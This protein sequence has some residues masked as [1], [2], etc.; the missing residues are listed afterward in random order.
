MQIKLPEVKEPHVS[1][2]LKFISSRPYRGELRY[3]KKEKG[4]HI[5][6]I[7]PLAMGGDETQKE[8]LVKL[9]PREHY[10]AHLILWK[11][12]GGK[13]AYAFR[14]MQG[15]GKITSRQ[16]ENLRFE[17]STLS[18]S[19]LLGIPLTAEHK[20]KI[21]QTRLSMHI[22]SSRE[23][24]EK[25]RAKN[26]GRKLS[27]ETKLKMKEAQKARRKRELIENR[28]PKL[29]EAQRE[30]LRLKNTG[31]VMSEETKQKIS[32]TEKGKKHS[33]KSKQKMRKS[34]S[35]ESRENMKRAQKLRRER[36]K[37]SH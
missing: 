5:H 16:Y 33:E 30:N 13:M 36:E 6:H 10:I 35:L 25:Q 24:I 9:T 19:R 21:S 31:K 1:R 34:K 12:Y 11:A 23:Q 3:Y 29:T 2:Y 8:N 37:N 18:R 20:Q 17:T 27:E 14:R 4:F 32:A 26:T 28:R 22:V 7:I 15:F